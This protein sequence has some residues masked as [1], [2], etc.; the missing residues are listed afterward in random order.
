MQ[1]FT[2]IITLLFTSFLHASVL[3]IAPESVDAAAWIIYDPQSEQVIAEHQS[4]VQRAP[5]SL[6]KM[7]VAY[8]TLKEIQAGRLKTTDI[9]TASNIVHVVQPDESQMFLRQGQTITVDQLLTGLIVMSANDAAVTLA[10]H[11]TGDLPH[12]VARMN[13]E[14]QSL[15]MKNTHFTNPAGITMEGHYSSAADLAILAHHLIKQYPNY[16]SYSK[17]LSYT[18]NGRIHH[19]TNGLLKQDPTVD[20]LKTGYTQAAG[21]NLALTA[22]RENYHDKIKYRRLIVVVLG[23][24]SAQKRLKVAD[25][26]LNLAYRYTQNEIILDSKQPLALFPVIGG[27]VKSYTLYNLQPQTITSSLYESNT[28][29]N[30]KNFDQNTQLLKENNESIQPQTQTHLRFDTKLVQ[31]QLIAPIKQSMILAS[32]QIFQNNQLIKDIPLSASLKLEQASWF[33]RLVEWLKYKL[34][35]FYHENLT[36]TLIYPVK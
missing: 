14:A 4:H 26:L 21:Y 12:F 25:Q 18:W 24:K 17:Q 36:K 1:T 10:E 8:I 31:Q 13:A 32:I 30:L 7:M 27:K 16:L 5:A 29:I 22:N 6:T 23:T 15:G 11:I 20:G 34:P 35:F 28:P 2:V 3:N 19:A 9:I 33:E